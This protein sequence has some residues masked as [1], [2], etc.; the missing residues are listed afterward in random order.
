VIAIRCA[1][2]TTDYWGQSAGRR[3]FSVVRVVQLGG[4]ATVFPHALALGSKDH[5]GLAHAISQGNHAPLSDVTGLQ[6]PD[7]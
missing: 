3:R 5:Q 2:T 4:P 1:L 7:S 6:R